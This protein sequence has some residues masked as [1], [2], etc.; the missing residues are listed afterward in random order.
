MI[1]S[2][3]LTNIGKP[4]VYEKCSADDIKRK[5]ITAK[6]K[7][8]F[9]NYVVGEPY[10]D[11]S[12][13][14]QARDVLDHTRVYLNKQLRGRG[15][16]AQITIGID[17]GVRHWVTVMGRRDDGLE[18]IIALA[19]FKETSSMVG[20][21]DADIK[22]II[23]FCHLFTPDLITADIGYNGNK[24]AKLIEEFG[25]RAYGVQVNPAKSNGAVHAIWNDKAQRVSIDKLTQN[26]IMLEKIKGHNLGFW[27]EMDEG[28]RLF[29]EHWMNVVIR[30]EEDDDGN[31]EKI[32]T[33]KGA[34]H[35][36]Q[37]GV[38]ANIAMSRIV[39]NLREQQNNFGYTT[40]TPDETQNMNDVFNDMF[41]KKQPTGYFFLGKINC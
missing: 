17:W 39:D 36:A 20:N 1:Q 32:I 15:N 23:M 29:I 10:Q 18:D 21:S 4:R 13:A 14:L 5:E 41:K 7:Q 11:I 27:K 31:I 25:D 3:P 40:L 37:S 26:R 9:H 34:D 30:D 22:S 24:V 12:L 35:Y 33:R 2:S 16:Y 19:N 38:Y 28:K 8:T 6:T